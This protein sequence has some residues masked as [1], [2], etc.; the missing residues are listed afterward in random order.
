MIHKMNIK[1]IDEISKQ[2]AIDFIMKEYDKYLNTDDYYK[3]DN[4]NRE[5]TAIEMT[6]YFWPIVRKANALISKLYGKTVDGIKIHSYV[7]NKDNY[8]INV[9]KHTDS[10]IFN[11]KNFKTVTANVSW[12]YYLNVPKESNTKIKFFDDNNNCIK[13]YLPD[14]DDLIIFDS[15]I[16]HTP[17][18]SDT[19]EYRITLNG[20]ISFT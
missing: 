5:Y 12:V 19:K 15:N 9:H 13:E 4:H 2:S 16:Y 17:T 18:K 10:V 3:D 11:Y 6:K 7:S 20:D 14:E 8:R 1:S